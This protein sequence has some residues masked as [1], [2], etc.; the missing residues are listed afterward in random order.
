MSVTI[1]DVLHLPS[2]KGSV[3][4]TNSSELKKTV[5]T[6]SVL[7]YADTTPMQKDLS[8]N[9]EYSGNELTLT[10][11]A[12]ISHDI[13]AQCKNIQ[14]LSSVGN[15]GMVIFYVGLIMPKIDAKLVETA[16]EL[17]YV[18]I[19]M[20][21]HDMSLA[22]SS[23]IADIMQAVFLDKM[24]HPLFAVDLI[25]KI[26]K[27]PDSLRSVS[28]VLRTISER[29]HVSAA[30]FDQDYQL[31]QSASWPLNIQDHWGNYIIAEHRQQEINDRF[32]YWDTVSDNQRLGIIHLL[33]VGHQRIGLYNRQQ[34]TE[35]LQITL[36]LW[37]H[38]IQSDSKVALLASIMEDEPIRMRRLSKFYHINLSELHHMW[39]IPNFQGIDR[40]IHQTEI[41]NLSA[42]YASIAICER[43]NGML[44]IM[45]KGDL[46]PA[47]WD[48]W[49]EMLAAKCRD[50]QDTVPICCQGIMTPEIV[51]QAV[52]LTK[53]AADDATIIFPK[54][55]VVTLGDLRLAEI[56]RR[57][58]R[59]GDQSVNAFMNSQLGLID[60]A[61]EQ[62]ELFQTLTTFLLD[63]NQNIAATATL[64]YVHPNTVKYR[65]AKLEIRFGFSI[66]KTPTSWLLYELCGVWRLVNHANQ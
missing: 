39:L 19:M 48:K 15:I 1:Q 35:V 47:V 61:H 20:P 62:T 22:Y 40:Q 45:P 4:L 41:A 23:V 31:L 43:Y 14:Q 26:S 38:N 6:V 29:L 57:R 55:D 49:G 10:A 51:R 9:I 12:S 53:S 8:E 32:L 2:M 33:L 66:D 13:N 44:Y 18:L 7:E 37:G 64:L 63:T 50:W 28:M 3:L 16:N 59:A 42:K 5:N 46:E 21:P 24:N 30:L 25:K 11:F 36:N 27:M 17:N 54:R 34:A 52:Q 60:K 65:L 56:C 58:I